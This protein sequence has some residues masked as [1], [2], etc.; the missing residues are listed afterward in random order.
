MSKPARLTRDEFLEEV[1]FLL[2][3][4]VS[5]IMICEQLGFAYEAAEQR[6]RRYDRAD[7]ASLFDIKPHHGDLRLK[8]R[9]ST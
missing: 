3:Q 1:D 7:I 9:F 6:L 4:G 8:T 5:P 2:F